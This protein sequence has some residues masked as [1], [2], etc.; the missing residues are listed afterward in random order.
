MN[1]VKNGRSEDAKVIGQ[2]FTDLE[3][4]SGFLNLGYRPVAVKVMIRGYE[5]L[6]V[7]QARGDGDTLWVA[8]F[9]SESLAGACRKARGQAREG[10]VRWTMDK[11]AS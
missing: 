1:E 6:L 10:N 7:V 8:F 3:D 11:W 2:F 5:T 9:G 4:N